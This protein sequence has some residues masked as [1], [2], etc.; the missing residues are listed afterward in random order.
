MLNDEVVEGI[1]AI[2]PVSGAIPLSLLPSAHTAFNNTAHGAAAPPGA[3][4]GSYL[5]QAIQDD[6]EKT[7]LPSWLQSAP[8]ALGT[9]GHG[10]A[11][12]DQWRVLSTIH[13]VITLIRVWGFHGQD[14]QEFRMLRNFVDL[15]RI[16]TIA[17]RRSTSF[18]H[19]ETLHRYMMSYLQGIKV[20]YPEV[21]IVPNHHIML[22]LPDFL[23]DFGPVHSIWAFPYERLNGILQS[24]KTNNRFG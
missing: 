16:A 2:L 13:A 22:H 23:R 20:M 8:K 14:T 3:I 10:K 9:T 21:N 7:L 5:L 6:N 19:R 1:P 15:A 4:L 11:T 12:A 17:P 18:A 24:I